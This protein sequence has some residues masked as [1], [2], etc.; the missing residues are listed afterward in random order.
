M[1]AHTGRGG[2]C[3][4]GIRRHKTENLEADQV[5][6]WRKRGSENSLVL[7]GQPLGISVTHVKDGSLE[8]TQGFRGRK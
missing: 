4:W 2:A 8:E 1:Q 7:A 5:W 3:F 6:R